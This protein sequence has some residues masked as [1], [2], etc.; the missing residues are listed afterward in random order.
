MAN[1]HSNPRHPMPRRFFLKFF[2][3][4]L[5]AGHLSAC[6]H[7]KFFNPDEDILLSGGSFTDDNT[8]QNA[9]VIINLTQKEKKLIETPFLPHDI[10]IDP[11]NKYRVFCF[12]KNGSR[13]CEIDLQTQTVKRTFHSAENRT[14]SGHAVFSHDGKIIYCVE[15]ELNSKQGSISI[16]DSKTLEII[17]QLPTLGLSPHDCQLSKDNVLTVSNTGK[18]ESG[19]HQPSLVSINLNTEKL[20]ERV[21][22]EN[23]GL[24]QNGLNCGHFKIT[25]NNDLVIAS[26]PTESK[27]TDLSGGV[28]IRKQ[29]ESISTMTEPDAVIKRMTGEALSIEINQQQTIAVITHPQ[30]NLLTFWSIKDK[31]IIKAYGFENPRGLSQTLD[32]KDF[33]VSYGNKPAMAKISTIDLSPQADSIVQPTLASGE[34]IIN[35]SET[36]REIMPK[37]IYD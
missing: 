3:V 35:W 2:S 22:L 30:A 34:H 7:K 5:I 26:A 17:K 14:F 24:Y 15:S 6:T 8:T 16:R 19:F 28:S 37:R 32:K 9:L 18:S 21:K 11:N 36:L 29:N 33:I 10:L 23:D 27:N 31:K 4:S 25:E 1:D 20:V 12:E 13:A